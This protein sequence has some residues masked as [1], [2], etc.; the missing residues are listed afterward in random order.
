MHSDCLQF[1]FLFSQILQFRCLFQLTF[2]STVF[3]NHCLIIP[4]RVSQRLIAT[5]DVSWDIQNQFL[6]LESRR[7]RHYSHWHYWFLLAE[8]GAL[9]SFLKGLSHEIMGP[10]YWPVWMHLGLNENRFWF[11]NFEEAP[12][13][14][15]SHFK[16]LCISVQTFSEIFRISKKDWQLSTQL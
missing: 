11:F 2:N 9:S 15:G 16:F 5:I 8:C 14:W 7:A 13:I 1:L 12:L 3:F 4:I 6:H 10:V